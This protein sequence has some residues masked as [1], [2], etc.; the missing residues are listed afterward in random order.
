MGCHSSKKDRQTDD[1]TSDASWVPPTRACLEST[2]TES[3]PSH[4]R[5]AS[6]PQHR[7]L[8]EL[9]DKR[10]SRELRVS[11]ESTI[12]SVPSLIWKDTIDG[13]DDAWKS[14]PKPKI[15]CSA[16]T[17]V[18]SPQRAK[19][20]RTRLSEKPPAR[21]SP[22]RTE[23]VPSTLVQMLI[24]EQLT[25]TGRTVDVRQNRRNQSMFVAELNGYAHRGQLKPAQIAGS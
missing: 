24:Q 10:L 11:G 20:T 12:S 23:N 15:S 1:L 14:M 21:S 25:G 16:A 19:L 22:L 17:V 7:R 4:S 2:S 13:A 9:R 6:P 3:S 5:D 18:S 8:N